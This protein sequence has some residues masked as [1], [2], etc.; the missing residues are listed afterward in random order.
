ML[1]SLKIQSKN[2]SVTDGLC[3]GRDY[4]KQVVGWIPRGRRCRGSTRRLNG[5]GVRFVVIRGNVGAVRA[6]VYCSPSY[7]LSIGRWFGG[8]RCGSCS[9]AFC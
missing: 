6:A 4:E 1:L 2:T 5:W 7:R 3:R 9:L 8:L